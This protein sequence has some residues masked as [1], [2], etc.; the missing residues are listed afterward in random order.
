MELISL[1]SIL[2]H[3]SYFHNPRTTDHTSDGIHNGGAQT[4]V[5]PPFVSARGHL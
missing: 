2:Q 1:T 4:I 3:I 5:L